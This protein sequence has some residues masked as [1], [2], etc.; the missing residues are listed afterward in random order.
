MSRDRDTCAG[1][2]YVT[3]ASDPYDEDPE[4]D[5]LPLA[6]E[7]RVTARGTVH[8]RDAEARRADLRR[9]AGALWRNGYSV[10]EIGARLQIDAAIVRDWLG[11]EEES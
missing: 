4:A 5:R 8:V 9:R 11:V 3:P 7:L 6:Y 1:D 2:D 10:R